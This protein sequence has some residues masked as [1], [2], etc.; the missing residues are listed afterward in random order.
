MHI[1]AKERVAKDAEQLLLFRLILGLG[2]PVSLDQQD[3]G[4][5]ATRKEP[6]LLVVVSAVCQGG[7]QVGEGLSF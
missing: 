2:P 4:P 5:R 6:G 3:E 1:V 7:F